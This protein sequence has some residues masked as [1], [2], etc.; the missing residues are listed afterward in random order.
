MQDQPNGLDLSKLLFSI[1]LPFHRFP[2]VQIPNTIAEK[3]W[4]IMETDRL[5]GVGTVCTI[6]EP[7]KLFAPSLGMES[8]SL[9]LILSVNALHET[10]QS[11]S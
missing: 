11:E 10:K 7:I 5:A 9:V 6:L 2:F 1:S 4:N 8:E 3:I